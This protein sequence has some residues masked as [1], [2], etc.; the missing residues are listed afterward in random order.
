MRE[1]I[2]KHVVRADDDADIEKDLVPYALRT[3]EVATVFANKESRGIGR[4]L[5]RY[6]AMLLL[7]EGH[8]G[9]EEE[10]ALQEGLSIGMRGLD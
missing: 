6:D 3:P 1:S 8:F 7:G 10:D 9:A 2:A 4:E 5:F